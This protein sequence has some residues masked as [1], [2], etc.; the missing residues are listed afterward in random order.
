L[1]TYNKREVM[2]YLLPALLLLLPDSAFAY[3]G[4]GAGFAF[5]GSTLVFVLTIGMAAITILF[6]PLQW[7]WK[8]ARNK[9]ISKNARARR[10]VIV[11][12][13]GLFT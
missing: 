3:I 5:L 10:V 1:D 12:L 13:D 2:K 7:I 4:P 8:K 9:G 11:G 6:W